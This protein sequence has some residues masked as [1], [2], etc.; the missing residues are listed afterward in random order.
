MNKNDERKLLRYV[1]LTL[2]SGLGPVGQNLLLS[3]CGNID[4]CFE[5]DQAEILAKNE[6]S[7]RSSVSDHNSGMDRSQRST[8]A[9]RQLLAF[10]EQREKPEL[11]SRAE[12]ILTLKP[13][14][15]R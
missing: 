8:V 11:R 7:I 1:M 3:V 13:Q 10:L 14:I 15:L 12:E 5:L 4:I 6:K 2:I 9:H